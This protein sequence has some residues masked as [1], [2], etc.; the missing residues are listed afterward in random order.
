VASRIHLLTWAQNNLLW[1]IQQPRR[2]L[3]ATRRG[4]HVTSPVTGAWRVPTW[5]SPTCVDSLI[6][7]GLIEASG[8]SLSKRMFCISKKGR[9]AYRTGVRL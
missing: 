2:R 1:L 6:R 9:E 7:L 8:R 4:W 5:A 3:R